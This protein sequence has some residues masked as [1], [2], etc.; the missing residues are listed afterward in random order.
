MKKI[1]E[2]IKGLVQKKGSLKNG[3]RKLSKAELEDLKSTLTEI[4]LRDR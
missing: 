2:K 3:E 4:E 1:K